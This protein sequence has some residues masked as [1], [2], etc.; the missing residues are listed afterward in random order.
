MRGVSGLVRVRR[1]EREDLC[2]SEVEREDLCMS[3]VERETSVRSERERLLTRSLLL[4]EVR[5]RSRER[6]L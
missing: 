6:D 4:T 3:E 5:V 2:M 1:R